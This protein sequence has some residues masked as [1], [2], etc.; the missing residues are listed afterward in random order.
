MQ[1]QIITN[2]VPYVLAVG[3]VKLYMAGAM[4]L[5]LHIL[6]S[7]YTAPRGRGGKQN[8]WGQMFAGLCRSDLYD[9]G[10]NGFF[11]TDT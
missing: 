10:A 2:K 8:R 11:R 1:I 9:T 4:H 5:W 3:P 6:Y 7:V